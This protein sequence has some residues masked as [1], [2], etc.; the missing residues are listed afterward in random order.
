LIAKHIYFKFITFI[1]FM[2]TEYFK[3]SK[4]FH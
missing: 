2:D 4:Y 1:T 3:N